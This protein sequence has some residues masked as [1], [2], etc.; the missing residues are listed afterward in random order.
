MQDINVL[1]YKHPISESKLMIYIK[2]TQ[3]II[4]SLR[5]IDFHIAGQKCPANV[6]QADEYVLQDD[7]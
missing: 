3:Q 7:E 2:T 4:G 1:Q 5:D 6:L